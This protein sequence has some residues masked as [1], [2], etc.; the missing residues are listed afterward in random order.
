MNFHKDNPT[1]LIHN[2]EFH[3]TLSIVTNYTQKMPKCTELTSV[4]I[5]CKPN[6]IARLAIVPTTVTVI[7]ESTKTYRKY[8][9]LLSPMS[10]IT[11]FNPHSVQNYRSRQNPNSTSCGNTSRSVQSWGSLIKPLQTRK[12]AD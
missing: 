8:V 1:K 12:P 6:Q 9:P 4:N 2:N 3:E 7:A 5:T 11:L 10:I